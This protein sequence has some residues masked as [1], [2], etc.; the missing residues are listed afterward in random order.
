MNNSVSI[1][2]LN[3]LHEFLCMKSSR[4]LG[5]RIQLQYKYFWKKMDFTTVFYARSSTKKKKE[6]SVVVASGLVLELRLGFHD[7]RHTMVVYFLNGP[8]I[9]PLPCFKNGYTYVI[10]I[11]NHLEVWICSVRFCKQ[12]F[13]QLVWFCRTVKHPFSWSL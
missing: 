10:V 6:E 8:K 12:N 4:V 3:S 13:K 9:R 1:I 11:L 2:R 7:R 5:K